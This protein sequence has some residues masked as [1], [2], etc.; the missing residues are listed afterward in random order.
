MS[1]IEVKGQLVMDLPGHSGH[2]NMSNMATQTFL[3]LLATL[4]SSC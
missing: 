3:M 4:L 2:P 1:C